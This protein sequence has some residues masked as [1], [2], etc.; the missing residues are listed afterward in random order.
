[1]VHSKLR[2]AFKKG[3]NIIIDCKKC[4][5]IYKSIF[6]E[7]GKNKTWSLKS[8]KIKKLETLVRFSTNPYKNRLSVALLLRQR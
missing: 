1:M 2:N 3:E 7:S 6:L 8:R 5:P 4:D